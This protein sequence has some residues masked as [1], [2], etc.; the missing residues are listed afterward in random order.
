MS[1]LCSRFPPC[2]DYITGCLRAL[3]AANRVLTRLKENGKPPSPYHVERL[4]RNVNA[5]FSARDKVVETRTGPGRKSLKVGDG[6][7]YYS[8]ESNVASSTG[9]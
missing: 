8:T 1:Q 2:Q 7:L 5:L 9:L 6:T 4:Q 3:L